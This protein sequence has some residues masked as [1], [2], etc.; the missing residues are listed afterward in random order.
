MFSLY[1]SQKCRVILFCNCHQMFVCHFHKGQGQRMVSDEELDLWFEIHCS[2]NLKFN[3]NFSLTK[4]ETL[5]DFEVSRSKVK[6]IWLTFTSLYFRIV[7]CIT[8][9]TRKYYNAHCDKFCVI[10]LKIIIKF[11]G[12]EVQLKHSTSKLICWLILT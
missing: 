11:I 1:P 7:G 5:T 10:I 6:V 2:W 4:D 9:M 3:T 12:N 8:S